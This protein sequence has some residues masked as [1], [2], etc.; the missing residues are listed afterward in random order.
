MKPW[1]I[2]FEPDL[3]EK[4]AIIKA[5]MDNRTVR[6][7]SKHQRKDGSVFPVE[8]N[9]GLMTSDGTMRTISV[10]RNIEDRKKYENTLKLH[11]KLLAMISDSITLNQPGY[12]PCDSK[13]SPLPGISTRSPKHWKAKNWKNCWDTTLSK[14]KYAPMSQRL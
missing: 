7:E 12:D 3:D 10:A 11:K 1:E 13:R 2:D 9:S 8:V 5:L 14:R 6:F 4:K